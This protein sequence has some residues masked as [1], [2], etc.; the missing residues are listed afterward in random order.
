MC[1]NTFSFSFCSWNNLKFLCKIIF[2]IIFLS[3]IFFL[4]TICFIFIS[5][6]DGRYWLSWHVQILPPIPPK[7]FQLRWW[8]K[9]TK[10]LF[11]FCKNFLLWEYIYINLYFGEKN[12]MGKKVFNFLGME[13]LTNERPVKGSWDRCR[14]M[15]VR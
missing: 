3:F 13:E 14:L 5:P 6:A 4:L 9:I 1:H 7:K 12:I 10:Q 2:H 8:K 15:I 11:F